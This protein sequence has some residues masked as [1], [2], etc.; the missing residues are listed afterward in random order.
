MYLPTISTMR[1]NKLTGCGIMIAR[2][3][4]STSIDLQAKL[5]RTFAAE[6]DADKEARATKKGSTEKT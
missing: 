2:N 1:I 5:K 3:K 4:Y 6:I